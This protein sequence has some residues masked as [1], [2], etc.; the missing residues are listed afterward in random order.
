M[1][2][3]SE[4]SQNVGIARACD[5]LGVPRASF[6]RWQSRPEEPTPRPSPPRA[7]SPQQRQ[8]VLTTLNSQEFC[9][10]APAEVYATL[11]DRKTY[12]CSIRPSYIDQ[13]FE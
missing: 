4:F 3:V 12:L 13:H 6:Y 10:R 2:C 9:D 11:L 5:V 7:L 1:G 8:E